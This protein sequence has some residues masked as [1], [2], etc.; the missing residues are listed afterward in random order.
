MALPWQRKLLRDT[1]VGQAP[2]RKPKRICYPVTV[3]VAGMGPERL[4][5]SVCVCITEAE[6]G[7]GNSEVR[8]AAACF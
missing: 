1:S 7:K 3:A 4:C 6:R 8:Q 2:G 5:V